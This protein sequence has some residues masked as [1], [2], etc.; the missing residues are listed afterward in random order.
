MEKVEI[1]IFLT[2]MEEIFHRSFVFLCLL[3]NPKQL[4]LDIIR[5]YNQVVIQTESFIMEMEVAEIL[6]FSI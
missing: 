5:V 1:H 2:I 4:D 3:N 6:M